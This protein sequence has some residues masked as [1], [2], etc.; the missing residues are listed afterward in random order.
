[1][2]ANWDFTWT[3]NGFDCAGLRVTRSRR[4][5]GS[6]RQ[7]DSAGDVTSVIVAPVGT[8]N[9]RVWG[10]PWAGRIAASC[11][12]STTPGPGTYNWTNSA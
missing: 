10:W 11:Q 3:A 12:P 4:V 1:M 5:S 6:N 7:N 8:S 9:T 2:A